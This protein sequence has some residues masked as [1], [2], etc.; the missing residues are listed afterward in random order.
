MATHRETPLEPSLLG[1]GRNGFDG[2]R[3]RRAASL[4]AAEC[5]APP[6]IPEN[7]RVHNGVEVTDGDT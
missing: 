3:P 7:A 1:E 6:A 2:E 4:E 5:S